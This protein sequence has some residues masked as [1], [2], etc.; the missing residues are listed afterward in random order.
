MYLYAVWL[1]NIVPLTFTE[2]IKSQSSTLTSEASDALWIA[3][4]W[5]RTSNPPRISTALEKDFSTLDFSET[6]TLR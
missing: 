2:N 6:S 3:A 5:A 1:V 4:G